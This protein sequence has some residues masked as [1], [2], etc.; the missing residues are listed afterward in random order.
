MK[1]IITFI[2]PELNEDT[3]LRN[4]GV[5]STFFLFLNQN[6][7]IC[8]MIEGFVDLGSHNLIYFAI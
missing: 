2:I 5:F 7:T 8:G 6:T 3:Q 1:H 4:T